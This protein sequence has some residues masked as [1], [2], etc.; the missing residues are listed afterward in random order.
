MWSSGIDTF[1][2]GKCP[3]RFAVDGSEPIFD[4]IFRG[5]ERHPFHNAADGLL[6]FDPM[7][8]V[9]FVT[10]FHEFDHF[11]YERLPAKWDGKFSKKCTHRYLLNLEHSMKLKL[12][13]KVELELQFK[14]KPK[15]N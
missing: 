13:R 3:Q 2:S 9:R 8:V 12:K 1:D 10:P 5:L 4:T 14:L 15:Q 7:L 11:P 6:H